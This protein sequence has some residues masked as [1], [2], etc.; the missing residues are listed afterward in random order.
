MSEIIFETPVKWPN[1]IRDLDFG[2]T[3]SKIWDFFE[4]NANLVNPFFSES[5]YRTEVILEKDEQSEGDGTSAK[6]YITKIKATTQRGEP[7]IIEKILPQITLN[8][9]YMV[10]GTPHGCSSIKTTIEFLDRLY[11]EG[12]RPNPSVES[13]IV[14]QV[15]DSRDVRGSAC[16][17]SKNTLIT[18]TGSGWIPQKALDALRK[19]YRVISE[20]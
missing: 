7:L 19:D 3:Y 9:L 8:P 6:D 13:G 2:E 18:R 16:I 11:H 14:L 20:K 10:F 5:G 4:I 17:G 12:Y 1:L 15:Y